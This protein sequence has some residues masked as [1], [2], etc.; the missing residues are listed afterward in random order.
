MGTAPIQGFAKVPAGGSS[1]LALPINTFK[2]GNLRAKAFVLGLPVVLE[3]GRTEGGTALPSPR[4]V[5]VLGV[6]RS[7]RFIPLPPV[8]RRQ[9]EPCSP[10]RSLVESE[11]GD[12][13]RG[14]AALRKPALAWLSGGALR[15]AGDTTTSWRSLW[16]TVC[17]DRVATGE[18]HGVCP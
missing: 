16:R 4:L 2:R 7:C 1:A 15:A 13:S 12:R 11:A 8:E 18:D 6:L 10:G 5:E 3:G 9:A 14:T 17:C